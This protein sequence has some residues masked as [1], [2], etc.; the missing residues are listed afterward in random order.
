MA[1]GVKPVPPPTNEPRYPLVE[2]LEEALPYYMALGVTEDRFWNGDPTLLN[3]YREAYRIRAEDRNNWQW[4]QG[5]YF[6]DALMS[7]MSA[8]GKKR[9]PY[10][11]EPL[12]LGESGHNRSKH[13]LSAEERRQK[14]AMVK[15]QVYM[16]NFAASFNKRFRA[17]QERIEYEKEAGAGEAVS[18]GGSSD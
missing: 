4:R 14:S 18:N 9:K 12:P 17:K 2:A 15:N 11:K 3:A 1:D 8:M 10:M 16:E 6:Y 13:E 5:L 7:A